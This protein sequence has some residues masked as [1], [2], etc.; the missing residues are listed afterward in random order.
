VTASGLVD[1][2]Y[3][4]WHHEQRTRFHQTHPPYQLDIVLA[5]GTLDDRVEATPEVDFGW[6]NIDTVH[7]ERLADHAPVWFQ[8]R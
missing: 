3:S 4:R 7:A 5:S 6:V 2:T 1:A 8:L